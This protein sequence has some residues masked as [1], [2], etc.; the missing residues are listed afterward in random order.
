VKQ[1]FEEILKWP[2]IVQGALG[3]A[4]FWLLLTL[5]EKLFNKLRRILGTLLL[6]LQNYLWT[7]EMQRK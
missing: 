1:I 3:S 6:T 7:V 2:I 5:G 4:L